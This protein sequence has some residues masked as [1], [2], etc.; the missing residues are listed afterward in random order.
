[1]MPENVIIRRALILLCLTA[2]SGCYA[3]IEDSDVSFTETN[4]CGTGNCTGNGAMLTLSSVFIPPVNVNLG[5]AGV[6]TSSHSKQGPITF[7]GSLVINK[8]TVTL[9]TPQTGDFSGIRSVDL[10]ASLNGNNCAQISDNCKSIATYDFTRDGPVTRTLV[11]KGTGANLLDFASGNSKTIT[12]LAKAT[13]NAPAPLTWNA[14]IDMNTAIK[15]RG[16]FP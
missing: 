14:D 12:V 2:L 13:G 11:I 6:F 4:V 8:A 15:A 7:D 1:M 16:S 3:E 5:D 9:T 10:R